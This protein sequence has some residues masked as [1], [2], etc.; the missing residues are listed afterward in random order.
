MVMFVDKLARSDDYRRSLCK[1]ESRDDEIESKNALLME[2]YNI[3]EAQPISSKM[4]EQVGTASS[5][6]V[7]DV[8]TENNSHCAN[9][10]HDNF[11]H[12]ERDSI[13]TS[14][15]I[16]ESERLDI[17]K[18]I[19]VL[20]VII[21]HFIEPY[22]K[23]GNRLAWTLMHLIYSFHIPAFVCISGYC[24]TSE[25]YF[26]TK[27]RRRKLISRLVIPYLIL[28]PLFC[29]WYG[30]IVKEN[31][32]TVEQE[33][34][35]SGVSSSVDGSM[36]MMEFTPNW[37]LYNQQP[38]SYFYPFSHLWYLISLLTMRIWSPFALEV[39]YTLVIHLLFG[40]LI[41]YSATVGRFLSLHRTVVFMPY[42]LCGCIMRQK[43][44]FF[45]YAT[46]IQSRIVLLVAMLMLCGA[47]FFAT[48]LNLKVEIWFQSD[49]HAAVYKDYYM[50][51]GFF[52][53][54]CYVWTTMVM[55]VFFA[56]IPPP[57]TC[58][59]KYTAV[60][61]ITTDSCAVELGTDAE[62]TTYL[63]NHK[64]GA[65]WRCCHTRAKKRKRPGQAAE[66]EQESVRA[67]VY[68]RFAKWGQRSLYAYVLHMAG[69]MI[70]VQFGYYNN[71]WSIVDA[72][73]SFDEANVRVIG[74][75]TLACAMTIGLLLRPFFPTYFRCLLEPDVDHV[76]FQREQE[77]VS[78]DVDNDVS[79]VLATDAENRALTGK[80]VEDS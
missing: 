58:G 59:V 6:S 48:S 68:L 46:S 60:A 36:M 24:T 16:I 18:F 71:L 78:V 80:E 75:V 15:N 37:I 20:L 31:S 74:T 26:G 65:S 17:S 32:T 13:I 14:A 52:Q 44:C 11:H 70:L 4:N 29:L 79:A 47:A 7:C 49:P 67:R 69:L 45:P 53:L 19:L 30:V 55:A 38:W 54:G 39:R 66:N 2:E 1:D 12:C 21:G 56:L 5:V 57:S 28:Q 40:C 22:Y 23:L 42:F 72:D 35:E 9:N 77:G 10:N 51:G 73:D 3:D 61:A 33:E 76:I 27:Y 50:Y 34:K 63:S 43:Q 8:D 62:E 64:H 25:D 41:G